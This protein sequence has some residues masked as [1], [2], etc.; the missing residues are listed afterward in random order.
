[1]TVHM[2]NTHITPYLG[3]NESSLDLEYD[4]IPTP[5]QARHHHSFLRAQSIGRQTG[6]IPLALA[7]VGGGETPEEKAFAHRSRFGILAVHEIKSPVHE[8]S[9]GPLFDNLLDFGYGLDA[10]SVYN[11]WDDAYPLRTSSDEA[12]TLLLRHNGE[13]MIVVCTWNKDPEQVKLTLDTRALGVDL[14]EARNA[15]N[16][17]TL[18]F[19][20]KAITL[21]LEGYAVRIL[22]VK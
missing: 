10:C 2:T 16:N 21:D 4:K 8:A 12:K 1:M 15:E 9:Y 5:Q 22:H 14:K 6:N 11:Y 3:W 19:D 7:W 18:A 13:V 20:G 17:E